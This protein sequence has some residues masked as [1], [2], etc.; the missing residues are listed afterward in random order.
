MKNFF[1]R[2]AA[3]FALAGFVPNLAGA[4]DFGAALR[5]GRKSLD[6]YLERAMVQTERE[7]FEKIAREGIAAAIFDWEQSAADLRLCDY[8]GWKAQRQAFEREA[9]EAAD[10]AFE[11]WL[12]DK[13]ALADMAVKK[14]ALYAELQEAAEKFF[15]SDESG[16]ETRI[17]PKEKIQD[18]KSQWESLAVKI[19]QKH[20]DENSSDG[21]KIDFYFAEEKAGNDL[22]NRLLYDHDS[23]KA[24]SDARAAMTLADA[25]AGQIELETRRSIEELFASMENEV[26]GGGM[27]DGADVSSKGENWL[28]QFEREVQRGLQKWEDAET[29]FLTARVEWERSAEELYAKDSQK[30]QKAYNELQ[31]RKKNWSEKIYEQMQ[32]GEREWQRKIGELD[33]EISAYMQD[34][35]K[36]LSW[37]LEQ[38]EQVALSYVE[39][40]S[41]SRAILQSARGGIESW[42][43][44]WSEKYKGLYSYWKSEDAEFWQKLDAANVFP[45][46]FRGAI[47]A[48]K[49]GLAESVKRVYGSARDAMLSAASVNADY[50]LWN[51]YLIQDFNSRAEEVASC[52]ELSGAQEIGSVCRWLYSQKAVYES[53][54][55][56]LP[57]EY[58]DILLNAQSFW[59]ASSELCEFLDLFDKFSAKADDFLSAFCETDF[60]QVDV[61][62]NLDIEK[63]KAAEL[64]K[65]WEER[66][67]IAQA[68]YDYSKNP[69]SDIESAQE[70]QRNLDQAIEKYKEARNACL[71]CM[72]LA[73][74]KNAAVESAKKNCEEALQKTRAAMDALEAEKKKH[75]DLFDQRETLRSSSLFTAVS[76]LCD[77][78][79]NLNVP[80]DEFESLLLAF[81]TR[82]R[83]EEKKEFLARAQEIRD[84]IENGSKDL[85]CDPAQLDSLPLGQDFDDAKENLGNLDL[86]GMG[87]L[88]MAGLSALLDSLEEILALDSFGAD[89][90]EPLI[91]D[92]KKLDA[93]K[94]A[95][96]L[97]ALSA[98]DEG[99]ESSD[100]V[101]SLLVDLASRARDELE[102]REAALLLID[103]THDEIHDFFDGNERFLPVYER[104]KEN[105]AA[106]M[107][108]RQE[109]A[110]RL[111]ALAIEDWEGDNLEDFF[112]RLDQAA[113]G[114]DSGSLAVLGLYKAA[115]SERS[116]NAGLEES[117]RA[118]LG[119][120]GGE[121]L[122]L[123]ALADYAGVYESYFLHEKRDAFYEGFDQERFELIA[124]GRYGILNELKNSVALL[125]DPSKE[126]Q[127]L[128][129]KLS[130]QKAAVEAAQ[131]NFERM[132]AG[133]NC[134]GENS[135]F[136]DY[137]RLCA[138]YNALIDQASELRKKAKDARFG[139]RLAQEI[140]F[141]G[142]NEYLRSAYDAN[143]KLLS[144]R[145]KLNLVKSYA[146]ALD[147][148]QK[149]SA[150]HEADEYKESYAQYAAAS[151]LAHRYEREVAAQKDR[152][153]QA[154]AQERMAIEKIVREACAEGAEPLIPAA[155][156]DLVRV[157][158]SADGNLTISLRSKE[159]A[160]GFVEVALKDYYSELSLVET[161]VYGNERKLSRAKNDAMDFLDSLS[162]KPYALSD[163]ALAAMFLENMGDPIS[164]AAWF[165]PNEDPQVDA[166]YCIGD[167]PDTVHFVDLAANY[168]CGRMTAIR[169][170]YLRVSA[171]G[172][173]D[174]IAKYILFCD[175]NFSSTLRCDDIRQNALKALALIQPINAARTSADSWNLAANV[176]FC[177]AAAFSAIACIPFVGSWASPIAAMFRAIAVPLRI[178]ASKLYETCN[179]I[180]L[181]Q[182]GCAVNLQD[183]LN[184]YA[185]LFGDLRAARE[186]VQKETARLDLLQGRGS[187]QE[188]P[189]TWSDFSKALDCMLENEKDSELRNFFYGLSGPFGGQKGVKNFFEELTRDETFYSV[190]EVVE[191]MFF[192]WET[193]KERKKSALESAVAQRQSELSFSM[194]LYCKDM[195]SF[196]ANDILKSLP[197][198]YGDAME[199]Y[200]AQV[201]KDALDFRNKVLLHS[202]KARLEKKQAL[203][204]TE[205]ADMADDHD[206]W[207][208]NMDA[209]L[210]AASKEWDFAEK[211]IAGDF[212]LWQKDWSE[213]YRASDQEWQKG[214]ADFLEEKEK[215]IF[216]QY[217][218]AASD[219]PRIE[220]S[221]PAVQT[222]AEDYLDSLCDSQKFDRILLA[223][224]NLSFFSDDASFIPSLFLNE[225]LDHSLFSNA[226]KASA[227]QMQLQEQMQAAAA[228]SALQALGASFEKGLEASLGLVEEQNKKL[229]NW[230]LNMVRSS[231]YTVDP[232]IHRDAVV[233]S[234][235]A[236]TK[237]Q[238][239]WVH[240]Y[241]WFYPSLPEVNFDID[242]FAG[243]SSHYVMKIAQE[244]ERVRQDWEKE[245]F[246][247][248]GSLQDGK[249]NEH[250]GVAPKFKKKPDPNSSLLDNVENLG[251]GQ[252]GLILLDYQWNAI[253]NSN[254]YSE[255]AKALYDQSFFESGIDFLSVPSFRDVVGVAFDIAGSIPPFFFVKFI[256]DAVFAAADLSMGFKR[257]DEVLNDL[258][259]QGASS[260]MSMGIGQA[261][262]L[263]GDSIKASFKAFE[264]GAASRL[265]DAAQKAAESYVC[266]NLSSTLNAVDFI[267]GK[268]D[269]EKAADSWLSSSS[270][271]SAVGILAGGVLDSGSLFDANGQTFNGNFFGNDSLKAVAGLNSTIGSLSGAALDALF[272]GD[273][274]VNLANVNGVGFLEVG[275]KDGKFSAGYGRGGAD[276]SIGTVSDI[277]KGAS[278]AKKLLSRQFGS[279]EDRILL[280]A[281]NI[282]SKFN[283][284]EIKELAAKLYDKELSFAYSDSANVNGSFE[285]GAF[286]FDKNLLTRGQAGRA[287]IIELAL[288]QNVAARKKM[289]A[290]P[291]PE[292]SGFETGAQAIEEMNKSAQAVAAISAALGVD[293]VSSYQ[294]IAI[295]NL[296]AAY[297]AGGAAGVYALYA[298]AEKEAEKTGQKIGG[299]GE[300]LEQP[301]FQNVAE[302]RGKLL[303]FSKTMEEYNREARENAINRYVEKC[304]KDE[305][306]KLGD[307]IDANQVAKIAR[308][309]AEREIVLGVA[310]KDYGYNPET[311]NLDI[312]NYGCVLATAA[313]IAYSVT[314]K[315]TTLA[316]AN[317][318]LKENDLYAYGTDKNGVTQK[319]LICSG[320]GYVKAVNAIAGA[321]CLETAGKNFSINAVE[322]NAVDEKKDNRQAICDRIISNS[323][324][325]DEVYYTCLRVN[326]KHS[327][328]LKSLSCVDE[329]DYKK[330]SFTVMDPWEGG[331]FE[332][333]SW[334]DISRADFY[335]L[336]DCGKELYLLTRSAVRQSAS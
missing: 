19:V 159:L 165:A 242:S 260:V 221:L 163:L 16:G 151:A 94:A 40:Y 311:Y 15:Y 17:V 317:E 299:L 139:C 50:F 248:D 29:N 11:R 156:R 198:I 175:T 185:G 53:I 295:A 236:N 319:N 170:A 23:L 223:A 79:K 218:G 18:A 120:L 264:S 5:E 6:G 51:Y 76:E 70:S 157:A 325:A 36:A 293:Q 213:R 197:V 90:L 210:N 100:G 331:K 226:L 269:W 308:E 199:G 300:L 77:M 124:S 280:S 89:A 263:I 214:Y 309:K 274:S 310:N 192:S 96:L 61:C 84:V 230:E 127:A 189:V 182:A 154:Q 216:N 32:E 118:A 287:E 186:S 110:R 72:D 251:S 289:E 188:K 329:K 105:S 222:L 296:V 322:V 143:G 247:K 282:Y 137:E 161:D 82:L 140:C 21:Q 42:S 102:T 149:E 112:E 108:E 63:A 241:E 217:A 62:D 256:D 172:G 37:E 26:D 69:F 334:S 99:G 155:A 88:S 158:R 318:I 259:R 145:E 66:V 164:R 35:Q 333:K 225:S 254:G 135:I 249:F 73:L 54:F 31:D 146:Q 275:V 179:D 204:S 109:A 57:R 128:E 283:D 237:R 20:L 58:S 277:A 103:G 328:L 95:E 8:E 207:K 220:F 13:K 203:F 7:R 83:D 142:Q 65:S 268:V 303:G 33:E 44:R 235:L 228:R 276:V 291:S 267:R 167:L 125:N 91:D 22:M 67:Q 211:K 290:A 250:I 117:L 162:A 244:L 279:N 27:D 252:M 229:E 152:L 205:A 306:A 116:K 238:T 9:G 104:Y 132:V 153:C 133:F 49:R 288:A 160:L 313:Y 239:Q 34:F 111:V 227:S 30:W 209:L 147:E 324:S 312:K 148:I 74:Q 45:E 335:K 144:A 271:A 129:E 233:A 41:Q 224:Q 68:V 134:S 166:Y 101:R 47:L 320:E 243:S 284:A 266:S 93:Q 184:N 136:L 191:K 150:I 202:Q 180:V 14:S 273:F 194:D 176:N 98:Y 294:S 196:Y 92:L 253:K 80:A 304:L 193:E 174:D 212:N 97:E 59:A 285:N 107:E 168:N 3:F 113:I 55:G 297:M 173:E 138:E 177:L 265:F 187:A 281:V 52:S 321:N 195:L 121:D 316:E 12:L 123:P 206:A 60:L 302:N 257:W 258:L 278:S 261:A 81:S 85:S 305:K 183:A 86:S 10:Q 231:G 75:D 298:D 219:I 71:S 201:F 270:V 330:N 1:C 255:L 169:D 301:F 234:S 56:S 24:Q 2:V 272:T 87:T 307:G 245:I 314:G 122:S 119:A 215:W 114:L 43:A 232:L 327:V 141:Y 332:P 240:R 286:V 28:A 25:L 46:D 39:A 171:S 126:I 130:A 208:Q 181:I 178:I 78:V 315:L 336:T 190:G 323:K 200:Q 48:W 115:L 246:G 106:L 38:K 292:L 326:D 64:V 131:K 4:S 262:G